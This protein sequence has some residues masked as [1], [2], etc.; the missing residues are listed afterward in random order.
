MKATSPLEEIGP[1][2]VDDPVRL[3]VE[4]SGA[5]VPAGASVPT[6]TS[7]GRVRTKASDARDAREALRPAVAWESSLPLCDGWPA[8]KD[9]IG[10]YLANIARTGS[11]E[12]AVAIESKEKDR[13][14]KDDPSLLARIYEKNSKRAIFVFQ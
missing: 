3:P 8:R 4:A 12:A 10:M 14:G 1:R 7:P 9:W 6:E 5:P 2:E 13:L 11:S